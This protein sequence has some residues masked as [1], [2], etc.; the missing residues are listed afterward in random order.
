MKGYSAVYS[1]L[2]VVLGIALAVCFAAP[3]IAQTTSIG[4][5]FEIEVHGGFTGGNK[6]TK[7]V[8]ALPPAG[9][10]FTTNVGT[11]TRSI[12]SWYFGDG[13]KLFNDFNKNVGLPTN[14]ISPLD[15][16]L[17]TSMM[18]RKSGGT[19]GVGLAIPLNDRIALEGNMDVANSHLVIGSDAL[20]TIAMSVSTFKSAF[21]L[22][23]TGSTGLS[24][25]SNS[26]I[27]DSQGRQI[28]TTGGLRLNL[29][30]RGSIMPFATAGAGFV[31]TTGTDTV[32]LI[33]NY[34]FQSCGGLCPKNETDM[35]TVTYSGAGNSPAMVF[36]GGLKSNTAARLGWR[37]N[38]R[39]YVSRNADTTS[40]SAIPTLAP[41][42]SG[43]PSVSQFGGDPDIQFSTIPGVR[44][45]LSSLT[46]D[47]KSFTG[48]GM[49]TQ[50][51]LT[52]GVFF[53]F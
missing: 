13:T 4:K 15:P 24:V 49:R 23:L 52:G 38:V 11:T 43:L 44:S 39:I 36:G 14:V 19:F 47:F 34:K 35:V 10:P 2:F 16:A 48:S 5:S 25:T 31:H 17:N 26:T 18:S 40:L 12:P 32:Q 7:G 6:V 42:E 51:T 50:A 9:T 45:S 1:A 53:R 29:L 8:G 21:T 30:E 28:F 20:S 22:V 37:V 27:V 46:S 3:A 33:G 41:A